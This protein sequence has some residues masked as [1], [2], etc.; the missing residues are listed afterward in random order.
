ML[1]QKKPPVGQPPGAKP[2]DFERSPVTYD[3][4]GIFPDDAS[5]K[6]AIIDALMDMQGEHYPLACAIGMDLND[7]YAWFKDA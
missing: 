5:L 4:M 1:K 2:N 3:C 7:D 6:T